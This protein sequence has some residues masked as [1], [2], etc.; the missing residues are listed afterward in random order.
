MK[1]KTSLEVMYTIYTTQYIQ[2]T[3]EHHL[4]RGIFLKYRYNG[5]LQKHWLII[6]KV[7]YQIGRC[8]E[9]KKN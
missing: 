2:T 8:G 9:N 1:L 7:K 5:M 4:I 6:T 3:I